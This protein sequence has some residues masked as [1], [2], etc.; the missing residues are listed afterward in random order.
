M[1]HSIFQINKFLFAFAFIAQTIIAQNSYTPAIES[2]EYDTSLDY[3]SNTNGSTLSTSKEHHKFGKQSLKWSWTAPGAISTKNFRIL[4]IDE[5]PLKYGDHFPASPTLSLSI[6]NEVAQNEKIKVSATNNSKKEIYFEFEINFT[7]WRTI[8]VP[9]YEMQGAAPAKGE[10]LQIDNFSISTNATNGTLYFDDI[11][12]S[13]YQD[14]RHS[15]PDKTV[16]F[17]KSDKEPGSDHW[18]PLLKYIDFINSVQQLEISKQKISDLNSIEKKLDNSIGTHKKTRVNIG[19]IRAEFEKLKL[20]DN[21]KTVLGPP[22]NFKQEQVYYNSKQQGTIK[23]NEINDLGKLIKNIGKCYHSASTAEKEELKD[24]FLMATNYY[25]DQGWQEGASGGT[26]HHIGYNVRELAEGFFMLRKTLQESNLLKEVGGSLQ[27][28]FNVGMVLDDETKFHVNLDYLNTQ[29]YYH[30]LLIFMVEDLNKQATILSAYA[31]YIGITLGQQ[32]QEWGFKIDGTAW[33]HNGHYPAYGMGAF[34]NVPRIIQTLSGTEFRISEKGH[35]NFK[36]AFL[37]TRTY[38]QKMDYGF[39][40][41]GRHPLEDNSIKSLKTPY[42]QMAYSGNPE[43]T[44]KIDREVASAYLRL[45]GRSDALNRKT[46][47]SLNNI[48]E[49]NLDGYKTFPYAATAVHRRNNWA[50][51]IKGYSKYVWSSEIYVGSNR[52]GRYPANGTIQLLNEKG[53]A[54]SGFKQKGWDWNRYPGATIIYL[55]FDELEPNTPLLM[56]RSAETFAGAVTLDDNGVFGMVLNESKGSNADGN[57]VNVGFPGKLKAKK[58]VFSFGDKLIC[59][60]T[61][62]SSIDNENPTQTNLFQTSITKANPP[63]YTKKDKSITKSSYE[64]ECGNWVIDTYGNGYHILSDSKVMTARKEQFSYHN[65]YS[66]KTGKMDPKGKGQKET[67][68]KFATA[69][70]EHGMNPSNASYQYVIYPFL[71][72]EEVKNFGKKI[73][74]DNS[75]DIL[76]ADDFAHIVK[77]KETNTDAYVIFNA[78]EPIKHGLITEVSE[79]ALIMSKQLTEKSYEISIVQPDLNFEQIKSNRYINN[80]RLVNLKITLKGIWS[81]KSDPAV[82]N[83]S[84]ENGN[85]VIEMVFQ[86]G[87]KSALKLAIN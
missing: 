15:Y 43:G 4:N 1:N 73:K 86:H 38:S 59:I 19:K 17:I 18:M 22:M 53:E 36:N 41:A 9:Y 67:K 25:L 24:M 20:V 10:D 26:R 3:Y 45:W 50:A 54:A 84:T 60:G 5:S 13:Q 77:D 47:T 71:K 57:E 82:K 72:Q 51:I 39:G 76:Q 28:L 83:I 49:E 62:I 11:V 63:T 31:N 40:N 58:S 64:K 52:Y 74:K 30:L 33:H 27:W 14:D 34:R 2:F 78:S 12:F 46:F 65:K 23:G 55:P 7:G 68:G 21:G 44:E 66:V 6:Y 85:T 69:W 80:S 81:L 37:A 61:G 75:Y 35:A 8:W 16:P 29:A 79:P 70:I 87:L 32:D 56:F 48:Q 42:L